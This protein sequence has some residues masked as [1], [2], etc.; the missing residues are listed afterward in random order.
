MSLST[1]KTLKALQLALGDYSGELTMKCMEKDIVSLIGICEE[2]FPNYRAK[3]AKELD[4]E[5]N[6]AFVAVTRAKRRLYVS[7]PKQRMIPRG[8]RNFQRKS[9]FIKEIKAGK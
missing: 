7:Y 4:E 8:D 3:T 6:N 1:S 2:V 9:Q 5:G